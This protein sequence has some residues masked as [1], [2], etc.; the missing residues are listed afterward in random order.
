MTDKQHAANCRWATPTLFVAAPHWL[1][2]EEYPWTCIRDTVPRA[3]QTTERC[4]DCPRW[5]ETP[6]LRPGLPKDS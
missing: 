3:L 6:V 2:A 5:E 1:D 4:T